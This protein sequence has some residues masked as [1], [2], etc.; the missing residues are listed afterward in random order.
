ME[1]PALKARK[2]GSTPGPG[3]AL[4]EFPYRRFRA[5]VYTRCMDP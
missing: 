3:E 5:Q 1:T 2:N 4:K